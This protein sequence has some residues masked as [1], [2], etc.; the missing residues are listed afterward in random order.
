[1]QDKPGQASQEPEKVHNQPFDEAVDVDDS[2]EVSSESENDM[3]RGAAEKNAANFGRLRLSARI[4][5]G[6]ANP[7]RGAGGQ[8]GRLIER[9]GEH[10]GRV[11]PGR[12][13]EPPG[14]GRSA[15]TV[16]IHL[17]VQASEHGA[18]H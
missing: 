14:V 11:Q 4:P 9:R 3:S 10:P 8:R 16:S 1:M 5:R 6:R 18:R 2:E 13:R 12:L 17:A 7:E 15:G